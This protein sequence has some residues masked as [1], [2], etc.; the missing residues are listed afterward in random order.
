VT[1]RM[2][3]RA[4]VVRAGLSLLVFAALGLYLGTRFRVGIDG[5]VHRCLPPYRVWLIDRHDRVLV[6]GATYS[7]FAGDA[8]APIFDPGQVVVKRLVGLPGD[9][10]AVTDERTTVN[11]EPV[12]AGLALAATLHQPPDAFVRQERIPTDA[13]WMMGDTPDSFDARYW[14]PLP[15]GQLRGRAHALF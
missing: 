14:G 15:L 7:F 13:V 2:A 3:S 4:F 8:L 11:G 5:Q 12:G 6:R 10:V 9:Q 1:N